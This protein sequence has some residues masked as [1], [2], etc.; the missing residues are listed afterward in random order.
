M[1]K[2]KKPRYPF[3]TMKVSDSFPVNADKV[4]QVRNALAAFVQDSE[5]SWNFTI[6]NIDGKHSCIRLK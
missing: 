5:P 3:K 1:A 2:T 4:Q 6:R